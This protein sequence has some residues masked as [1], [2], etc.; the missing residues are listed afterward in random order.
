VQTRSSSRRSTRPIA[1]RSRE[2]IG[3][4]RTASAGTRARALR[5]G[6]PA[7][8]RSSSYPRV[9]GLRASLNPQYSGRDRLARIGAGLPPRRLVLPH[10]AEPPGPTMPSSLL[11]SAERH[12]PC[13]R[14]HVP[15]G[16]GRRDLDADAARAPWRPDREGERRTCRRLSRAPGEIRDVGADDDG[17]RHAVPGYV[18]G[19]DKH[20]IDAWSVV[21]CAYVAY[22]RNGERGE[23]PWEQRFGPAEPRT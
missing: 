4:T 5:R 18:V 13:D 21:R 11:V 19:A 7:R 12:A 6:R 8:E 17:V 2:R 1:P 23:A 22:S 14:P 3:R 9:L 20:E 16:I 15:D 10:H